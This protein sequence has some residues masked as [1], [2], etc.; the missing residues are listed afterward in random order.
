MS[1]AESQRLVGLN[2]SSF[3]S[4]GYVPAPDSAYAYTKTLPDLLHMTSDYSSAA[5]VPLRR[6]YAEVAD[7]PDVLAFDCVFPVGWPVCAE[8]GIRCVCLLDN[9]VS[10]EL[11]GSELDSHP[12]LVSGLSKK[13]LETSFAHVQF[14]ACSAALSNS[15][16][17]RRTYFKPNSF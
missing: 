10:L 4:L 9:S 6:R 16:G 14:S 1:F 3:V 11:L 2:D 7:R 12:A 13:D 15:D 17:K 8:L 5:L